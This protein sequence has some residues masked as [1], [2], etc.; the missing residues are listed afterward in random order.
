MRRQIIQ[1]ITQKHYIF[2]RN[3]PCP[4]LTLT[5]AVFQRQSYL[6]FKLQSCSET[7]IHIFFYLSIL[8]I[9]NSVFRYTF[10]ANIILKS[11][12][13]IYVPI[14]VNISLQSGYFSPN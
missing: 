8:S 9:A 2:L 13:N 11:F 12:S 1:A 10:Y 5:I 7:N 14:H 6:T 4:R 3:V